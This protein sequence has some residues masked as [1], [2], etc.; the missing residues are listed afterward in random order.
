MIEYK[1]EGKWLFGSCIPINI[2]NSRHVPFFFKLLLYATFTVPIAKSHFR[3]A[4]YM[5][6]APDRFN[7]YARCDLDLC[8]V[9]GRICEVRLTLQLP[10]TY[11]HAP[12]SFYSIPRLFTASQHPFS[13]PISF[14]SISFQ[15]IFL[16]F[17]IFDLFVR[18]LY[19]R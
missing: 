8:Q 11:T 2:L 6:V 1:G 5:Y 17:L 10:Y 4:I 18:R 7:L 19:I 15:F 9:K 3:G 16:L 13:F 12:I 14:C